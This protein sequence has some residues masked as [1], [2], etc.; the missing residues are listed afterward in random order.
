MYSAHPLLPHRD[1]TALPGFLS[2]LMAADVSSE[3][4]L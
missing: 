1:I 3:A 4:E 2:W